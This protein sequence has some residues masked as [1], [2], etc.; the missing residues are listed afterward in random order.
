MTRDEMVRS[1]SVPLPDAVRRL[2]DGGNLAGAARA[3]DALLADENLPQMMRARLMVEKE[4]MRRL[5]E[6]F[7]DSRETALAK[8]RAR[9]PDLKDA[10]FQE[11]ED[12]NLF[13]WM[14][15]DGEKRYFVRNTA[16]IL[17]RPEYAARAGNPLTAESPFLDPMIREIREKGILRKKYTVDVAVR[18][19]AD[20]FQPGVYHAW[21]P[22]PAACAQQSD[23]ALI[24]GAPD[25]IAPAGAA[26]RCA[27]WRREMKHW[28][29][30]R[31]RYTFTSTIRYADPLGAEA[32]AAPLYPAAAPVT[33]ADLAEDPPHIRFTPYLRALAREW[34]GE[35]K[36]PAWKAWRI[37]EGI[38]TKV[39]YSY[40][41]D[42]FL[43]D[44]LGEYCA[45]DLKGDCGLQALLFISLCRIS[46]IP[47]RWQSGLSMDGEDIGCHDWAQFFL[48][49]WGWLFADPSYGGGA[50]HRGAMERHR[51]YFGNIDPARIAANRVFEA[52]LTPPGKALRID[53]YDHQTAEL[54]REGAET[55]FTG[56]EFSTEYTLLSAETV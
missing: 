14:M 5:P 39:N 16:L 33:D 41:P 35:E 56:A 6:Q 7:P 46:G 10:E 53:P 36:D 13:H 18:M 25:Q 31:M 38:T 52:E 34:V 50:W 19:D 4:R 55:A 15:L 47:A 29:D 17:R 3:A 43:V 23:E 12:R 21:L 1:L 8:L 2:R 40:M 32:P 37:Y 9:I 28:E 42:Y 11:M 54:E 20:A 24:S 48:P 30:F 49:G 45:K 27:Y 44:D 51:F 26:A 22:F